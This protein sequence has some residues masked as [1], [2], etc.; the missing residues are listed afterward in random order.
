MWL[1]PAG[2]GVCC[3]REEDESHR[4]AQEKPSPNPVQ[5]V[6]KGVPQAWHS[7]SLAEAVVRWS[8]RDGVL[9]SDLSL[10]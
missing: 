4:T 1:L 10:Q 7:T 6:L 3:W 9:S 8:G 5:E 2:A